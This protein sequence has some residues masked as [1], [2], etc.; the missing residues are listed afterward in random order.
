MNTWQ[1]SPAVNNASWMT[2]PPPHATATMT[3]T[4]TMIPTSLQLCQNVGLFTLF[5]EVC[6]SILQDITDIY[7]VHTL[8]TPL[9]ILL[10]AESRLWYK[11]QVPMA[12]QQQQSTSHNHN[13]CHDHPATST[14]SIMPQL[15]W[16]WWWHG[17]HGLH[18]SMMNKN[19]CCHHQ[20]YDNSHQP[21]HQPPP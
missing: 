4:A 15:Q 10:F 16:K 14:H 2:Q 20:H 8:H 5:K 13:N 7:N 6:L 9:T 17:I 12:R 18:A 1:W 3:M 21:Q 19:N 11:T